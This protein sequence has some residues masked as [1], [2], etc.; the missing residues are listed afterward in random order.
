MS[1]TIEMRI[2]ISNINEQI[3]W[4]IFQLKQQAD[5]AAIIYSIMEARCQSLP[6]HAAAS[7]RTN[8]LP[9]TCIHSFVHSQA[10]WLNIA[11]TFSPIWHGPGCISGNDCSPSSAHQTVTECSIISDA[12]VFQVDCT[13]SGAD[14]SHFITASSLSSPLFKRIVPLNSTQFRDFYGVFFGAESEI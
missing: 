14:S 2:Y 13:V 12:T 11:A 8:G 7:H 5:K 3:F 4:F 6:R 9:L 1:E 10:S